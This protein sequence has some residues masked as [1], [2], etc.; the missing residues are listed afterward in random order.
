MGCFSKS[1]CVS[2]EKEVGPFFYFLIFF[3]SHFFMKGMNMVSTS[4]IPSSSC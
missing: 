2:K 4:T 1:F 3:Q